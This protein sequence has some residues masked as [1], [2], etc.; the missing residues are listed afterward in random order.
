M[1][2]RKQQRPENNQKRRRNWHSK[3]NIKSEELQFNQTHLIFWKMNA[4]TGSTLLLKSMISKEIQKILILILSW[5]QTLWLEITKSKHWPRC[6]AMKG[7]GQELLCCHAELAKHW[8]ES[9]QL[10][11]SKSPFLLFAHLKCQLNNGNENFWSGVWSNHQTLRSSLHQLQS[12]K[13]MMNFLVLCLMRKLWFWFVHTRCW[14]LKVRE[15][16]KHKVWWAL[17]KHMSGVWCCLM[18]FRLYQQ[19]TLD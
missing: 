2:M 7:L 19:Q 12:W 17:S 6:S 3:T 16:T 4:S 8:L 14:V 13:R 9:Q 18:K 1:K 11:Q 10:R 15:L 5:N